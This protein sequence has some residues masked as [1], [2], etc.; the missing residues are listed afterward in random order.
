MSRSI[1]LEVAEEFCEAQEHLRTKLQSCK[2]RSHSE[3][4]SSDD[5]SDAELLADAWAEVRNERRTRTKSVIGSLKFVDL[6]RGGLSLVAVGE[7]LGT[8]H[9]TVRNRL[10][11]CG[12]ERRPGGR[13]ACGVNG[14]ELA[15]LYD[16]NWS[17]HAIAAKFGIS[18]KTVRKYLALNG[19]Q[20]RD[21]VE[22]LRL[23]FSNRKAG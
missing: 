20:C 7:A 8:H 14:D 16:A 19:R 9:E 13:R 2:W 10:V 18:P 22:A 11:K 15:A 3:G 1:A 4:E 23:R 17:T 5:L 6:Y 12:V 21:R